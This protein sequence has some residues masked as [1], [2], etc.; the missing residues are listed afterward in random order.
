MIELFIAE[1][2]R[3]LI[4]M[5]RYPVALLLD[6]TMTFSYF[7]C[8]FT[9]A[10]YFAKGQ[11]MQFGHHAGGMVLGYFIWLIINTCLGHVTQE[12]EKE[13]QSGTL[14]NIFLSGHKKSIVFVFRTFAGITV[15]FIHLLVIVPLMIFATGVDLL[16]P[17]T[18]VFPCLI[19]IIATSGIGLV[20]GGFAL[21][22]KRFGDILIPVQY[23]VLLVLMIP[24]ES[25]PS[26][27]MQ[28][29]YFMPGLPGVLFLRKIMVFDASVPY[30]LMIAGFLN[31]G[32]YLFSGIVVFNQLVLISKRRGLVGSY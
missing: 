11:S 23:A 3:T 1:L 24:S 13:A 17:L 12:I 8:L 30:E 27:L 29:S 22:F 32:F 9:G 20:I 7:Y 6:I 15:C 14:E 25:W 28:I 2:A 4:L 26:W 18:I 5:I 19:I 31:A 16:F 10:A 21:L